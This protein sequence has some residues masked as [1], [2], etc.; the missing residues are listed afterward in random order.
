MRKPGEQTLAQPHAMVSH[1]SI[2]EEVSVSNVPG[3]CVEYLQGYKKQ[4]LSLLLGFSS[5]FTSLD[6][7]STV[8]AM[9]TVMR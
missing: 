3:T 4:S 5:S 2:G 6:R 7:K 1:E 9:L 8:A